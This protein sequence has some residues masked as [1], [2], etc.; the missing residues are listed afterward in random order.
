MPTHICKS[1]LLPLL[2]LR[3]SYYEIL[4]GLELTM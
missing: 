1:Y 4:A 2:Q 3:E